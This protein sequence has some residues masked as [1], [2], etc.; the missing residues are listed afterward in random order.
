MKNR[1]N[2]WVYYRAACVNKM[3]SRSR[4]HSIAIQYLAV[5]ASH[6]DK[7]SRG[8]MTSFDK[9]CVGSDVRQTSRTM[10]LSPRAS[11]VTDCCAEFSRPIPS[12]K[13]LFFNLKKPH[14]FAFFVKTF[15]CRLI[16]FEKSLFFCY[17]L[18]FYL[19]FL[20]QYR[21]NDYRR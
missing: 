12:K 16:K 21:R 14:F 9:V 4:L 8:R 2:H 13:L 6:S 19:L 20:F 7:E 10:I 17:W 15:F 5:D 11:T 1:R 18:C 3:F